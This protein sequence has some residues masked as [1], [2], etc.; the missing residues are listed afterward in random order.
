MK[1]R[2]RELLNRRLFIFAAAADDPRILL[3]MKISETKARS[4]N[5]QEEISVEPDTIVKTIIYDDEI[6]SSEINLR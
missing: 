2:F 6:L 4:M 5:T 1:I 3:F